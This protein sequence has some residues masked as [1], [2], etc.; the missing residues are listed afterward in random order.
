MLY[1][2]PFAMPVWCCQI[3]ETPTK[4]QGEW[5][6]CHCWQCFKHKVN[7][8]WNFINIFLC[9]FLLNCLY[10]DALVVNCYMVFNM[11]HWSS[12]V[13]AYYWDLSELVREKLRS[14]IV[15]VILA[16]SS[17]S[18]WVNGP[19][20][21]FKVVFRYTYWKSIAREQLHVNLVLT[22]ASTRMLLLTLKYW[23]NTRMP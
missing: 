7:I 12:S 17:L 14:E 6:F 23:K 9:P 19:S 8:L 13:L 3:K 16:W 21:S 15:V 22:L 10:L 1:F 18:V 5:R 2:I 4:L 11:F 20:H